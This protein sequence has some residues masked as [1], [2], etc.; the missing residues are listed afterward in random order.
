M[1][2]QVSLSE[3]YVKSVLSTSTEV[4]NK[5]VQNHSSPTTMEQ[6]ISFD[7]CQNIDFGSINQSQMATVDV[8]ATLKDLQKADTSTALQSA[9]QALAQ[10]EATGG[11]G[12]SAS[13][14]KTVVDKSINLSNRVLN[15]AQNNLDTA[16]KLSQQF[17]CTNSQG[18]KWGTI[19]QSQVAHNIA[20]AVADDSQATQISQDIK[21]TIDAAAKSKATGYDPMGIAMIVLAV[22]C[23]G[24]LGVLYFT[25][26]IGT[27]MKLWMLL[28]GIGSAFAIFVFAMS[29][30]GIW[31]SQKI[32][33]EFDS[34]GEI[35]KKTQHNKVVRIVSGVGGGVLGGL[36]AGLYYFSRKSSMPA[37]RIIQQ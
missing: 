7:G 24:G 15:V 14:A 28:S 17:E 6:I 36:A 4:V 27:S 23:V 3:T 35:T 18:I 26:K 9:V 13:D 12:L 11:F 16:V 34:K 10:A 33:K 21:D 30:V 5:V 37:L 2:A 25:G 22:V 31:P 32:D 20:R 19:D 1:G 8:S 29:F